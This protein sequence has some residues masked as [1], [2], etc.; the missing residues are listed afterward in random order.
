MN[1]LDQLTV[2]VLNRNW[3]AVGA[4][5]PAHAF[6]QLANESARALDIDGQQRLQPVSFAEWLTLPVRDGDHSVGTVHGP[7]RLPT[8]ILL[9]RFDKVPMVRPRFSARG[10][11]ERDG[12]KCQYTGKPLRPGEGNIDHVVPRSRGGDNSWENCVLSAREINARKA[13]RTPEE[14]GLKL[15]R[16]P[17]MPALVPATFTLR[18]RHGI[19]DWDLFLKW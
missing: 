13:D 18:N 7:I 6:C 8:V 11:R 19:A 2:L 9:N 1:I 10:I 12:G 4:T 3:M 5:T 16:N 15:L 14:A 17:R